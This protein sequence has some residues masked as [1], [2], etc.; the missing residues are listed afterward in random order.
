MDQPDLRTQPKRTW[1]Q[2]RRA[3]NRE[4]ILA[5]ALAAFERKGY[6]V[7]TVDDILKGAGIGRTSFYKH[8]PD[9]LAVVSALFERFAPSLEGI[10]GSLADT[11]ILSAA[12]VRA[13]LRALLRF[14]ADNA[15]IMRVFAQA[16]LAEPGFGQA[17]A[18][19]QRRLMC[20]LGRLSRRFR[21]AAAEPEGGANWTR[22]S[23][24]LRMVDHYCSVVSLQGI[25][26]DLDEGIDMM[27]EMVSTFVEG[28]LDVP[29][30]GVMP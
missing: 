24:V 3:A 5:S 13:W 12:T 7:A 20:L 2:E 6:L 30:S 8:F 23:L 21:E 16:T 25:A 28:E 11:E 14:Y 17:I 29:A 4:A 27:A 19:V 15:A 26:Y 9:K 18:G 10:Y 22:A 1:Q